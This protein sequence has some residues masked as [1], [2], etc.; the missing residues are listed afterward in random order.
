MTKLSFSCEIRAPLEKVWE[1]HKSIE[2]LPTITPPSVRV[3]LPQEVEPP[4]VG[5]LYP[6]NIIV[7]GI[8]I[9]W[10]AEYVEFDPPNGFVDRQVS[11][12]FKSWEHTHHFTE[13]A[14]G[15][16][17]EDTLTYVPPFGL[18]GRLADRLIIRR[19]LRAMFAY[20]Y[21]ETKRILEE[22]TP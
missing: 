20:R 8:V 19:E 1:F 4:R 5:A 12:P 22:Q 18:L 9:H 17:V 13:T 11:G 14:G 21:R 6:M 15:T 10:T 3:T 2:T 7:R 16:L